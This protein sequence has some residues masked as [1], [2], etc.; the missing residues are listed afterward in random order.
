MTEGDT[1]P[2]FLPDK[3]LQMRKTSKLLLA[4]TLCV[5]SSGAIADR[6][7]FI[8]I[9]C[10]PDYKMHR[11]ACDV[12]TSWKTCAAAVCDTIAPRDPGNAKRMRSA[13]TGVNTEPKLFGSPPSD[14][15]GK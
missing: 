9:G 12:G 5:A 13:G 7:Y 6:K 4:L 15:T 8:S 3:G 11:I 1:F 14:R 10:Y 2:V